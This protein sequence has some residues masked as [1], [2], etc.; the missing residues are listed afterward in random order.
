MTYM[1]IDIFPPALRQ[2]FE[3]ASNRILLGFTLLAFA[4]NA[5]AQSSQSV[6]AVRLMESSLIESVPLTGSV[7]AD[8]RS[9]ISTQVAGLVHKLSVDV[10]DK[11]K[12]GDALLELDD[13]LVRIESEQAKATQ[14]Q[15]QAQWQNSQRRLKEAQELKD[16]AIAASDVRTRESQEQIDR[17]AKDGAQAGVDRLNAEIARHKIYAPYDGIVSERNVNLGE[18]VTPGDDLIGL[19]ATTPLWIHFQVPQRYYNQVTESARVR[20]QLETDKNKSMFGTISR[21]VPLSQSGTRTFLIRVTPPPA[22]STELIPGMAMSGELQLGID[23]KGIMVPRDALIRYPDGRVTV[24]RV[25]TSGSDANRT[26]NGKAKEIKVEPGI[27][28]D[29]WVEVN[30]LNAGD[31][32]VT[33]GNEALQDNMDVNLSKI[34]DARPDSKE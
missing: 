17:A 21:K 22:S 32:V 27:S 25:D 5:K 28:N 18:W 7:V 15:A 3:I 8:Q 30:G 23:R 4:L 13:E 12:K 19:V 33:R 14:L 9:R 1:N 6:E 20:L 16:T 11:V 26:T 31:L 24:W 2:K 34:I 10:G 29:G